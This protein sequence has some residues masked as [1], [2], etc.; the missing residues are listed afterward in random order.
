MDSPASGAPPPSPSPRRARRWSLPVGVMRPARRSL[1]S[2]ALLS[3]RCLGSGTQLEC[4]G[5]ASSFGGVDGSRRLKP[6]SFGEHR[7]HFGLPLLEVFRRPFAGLVYALRQRKGRSVRKYSAFPAIS[8]WL[9]L[10][11]L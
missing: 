11:V 6:P 7:E 2:C 5:S 10:R 9:P 8:C 1:R 4:Q 3:C